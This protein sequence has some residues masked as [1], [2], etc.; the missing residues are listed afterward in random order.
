MNGKLLEILK[1]K[2]FAKQF[3]NTGIGNTQFSHNVFH[4]FFYKNFTCN[5]F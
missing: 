3:G 1:S 2:I 5:N 4:L